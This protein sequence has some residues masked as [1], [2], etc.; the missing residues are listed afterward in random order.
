MRT[1]ITK[2]IEARRRL[3][4]SGTLLAGAALTAVAICSGAAAGPSGDAVRIPTSGPSARYHPAPLSERFGVNAQVMFW[5]MPGLDWA[6]LEAEMRRFSIGVVRADAPWGAVQPTA[7]DGAS[8]LFDWRALDSL[9]HSLA[10]EGLRWL[11]VID[12]SAPWA[13]SRRLASG[14][15]NLQSAPVDD[16]AFAR[17]A[18]AVAARYGPGGPFWRAHPGLR[19]IPVTAVEIWNEEN[20]AFAWAP[21]P[22]ARAYLKLY[23]A[24]R[25]SIHALTPSTEVLVGGLSD[26][27]WPFIDQL[28][29]AG[30]ER[31]DLFDGVAIHPYGAT[32]GYALENVV[33]A[34][35]ALDAHSDFN[36]PL[37]VTE[38]G[39]PSISR[40]ATQ[41]GLRPPSKSNGPPFISDPQR[42]SRVA[43]ITRTLARSDCGVER[44]L[45]DTWVTRERNPDNP[46]DWFGLVGAGGVPSATAIAYRNTLGLLLRSAAPAHAAN[47]LCGRSLSLGAAGFTR[48]V[49]VHEPYP[50]S[51]PVRSVR[52]TCVRFT[53]RSYGTPVSDIAVRIAAVTRRGRRPPIA[54]RVVRTGPTGRAVECPTARAGSTIELRLSAERPDFAP[55]AIKRLRI[56]IH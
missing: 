56:R 20:T 51:P 50:I 3:R 25:S 23:A 32:V 41:R 42:A 44:I 7:A 8:Q 49:V 21:R 47:R 16:R 17:F 36:T 5:M 6:P 9:E 11:P 19:E 27:A 24:A 35:E 55:V 4:A 13:A 28:Y 15:P 2:R 48:T 45:P 12:Y 43:T 54:T 34:R 31:R 10:S 38:F 40:A 46:E 53:V 22:D 26:P 33:L 1:R 18:A 52:R 29:S 30:G 14:A 37:D 39:W